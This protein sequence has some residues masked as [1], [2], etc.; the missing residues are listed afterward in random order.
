MEQTKEEHYQL[1]NNYEALDVIK[2]VLTKDEYIGFLKGNILKYK[3]RNKGQDENDNI[4]V[5]NYQTELNKYI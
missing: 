2:V 4:K 5:K 3:L 1:W